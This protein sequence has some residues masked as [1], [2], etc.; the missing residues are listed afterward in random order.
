[1]HV[2]FRVDANESIGTGHLHRCLNIA[3]EFRSRGHRVSLLTRNS[4]FLETTIARESKIELRGLDQGVVTY[5][6][7]E[8]GTVTPWSEI[9][10]DAQ[11]SASILNEIGA[12]VIAVDHYS[13]D[14]QWLGVV[15]N[16]S[17]CRSLVIDDLG[18]AWPTADF[19]LDSAIGSEL[20]YPGRSPSS[21][22]MFGPAFAPLHAS[23]KVEPDD[24]I[25]DGST[26]RVVVFFGGVDE[27]N[28]T[29]LTL[30]EL[31][32]L[33]DESLSVKVI[34]GAQN[35]HRD[36]LR[37]EFS[38]TGFDFV[39][40]AVSMRTHLE[41]VHIS[42]GAGGTTTWERLRMGVPGITVA[43]A[44]NQV[45]MSRSL[46]HK[47]CI[48]YL[49]RV[50]ELRR[51]VVARTVRQLIDDRELREQMKLKGQVLVD[52]S[53]TSRIAETI[54]P[55]PLNSL[56]LRRCQASDCMT[57]FRWVNDP[58]VRRSSLNSN[59]VEWSSHRSWFRSMITDR[60]RLTLIGELIGM[61][62]GQIR[63]DRTGGRIRLSYSIEETQ[64][65]KGLGSWIVEAGLRS[66][67]SQWSDPVFA[68]VQAENLASMK[69]FQ[70]LGWQVTGS[71]LPGVVVFEP[72]DQGPR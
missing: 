23:Y 51:G 68:E 10:S 43:I 5:S 61:P 31:R 18:R 54:A 65:G 13:L 2:A 40:P 33:R 37:R 45:D 19:L 56:K 53:G 58:V 48:R 46:D 22:S 59:N 12:D 72:H 47:G 57:L 66:L 69:V 67:R 26:T 14:D 41:N 50:A 71:T 9:I 21:K 27:P 8:P 11:E 24:P 52:G 7:G 35:K 4:S 36:E 29:G 20:R 55:S 6:T 62:V 38:S 42:L 32:Q 63:F 25:D 1:M 44:E 30:R 39:P 17:S 15:A 16:R 60:D 28:A 34:V 70:S 3:E 64:R 49:G